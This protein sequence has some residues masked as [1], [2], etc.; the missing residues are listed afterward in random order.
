VLE[1]D[2]MRD[3]A[4]L[5]NIA[6]ETMVKRTAL[7]DYRVFISRPTVSL[8]GDVG[9]V[10]GGGRTSKATIAKVQSAWMTP[11]EK[12]HAQPLEASVN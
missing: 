7:F 11:N 1:L 10:R 9:A 8:S 6:D 2:S 5:Q 4:A 3:A 12:A